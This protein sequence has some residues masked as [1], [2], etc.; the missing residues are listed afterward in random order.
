MTLIKAAVALALIATPVTGQQGQGCAP[1][2]V[3]VERLASVY[4]ESVNSIALQG[5]QLLEVFSNSVTGTFTILITTA[6]GMTCM[7]SS[8]GSFEQ[9]AEVAPPMGKDGRKLR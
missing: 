9:R 7:I 8:G 3:M 2:E 5:E 4:G 1:R 6:H